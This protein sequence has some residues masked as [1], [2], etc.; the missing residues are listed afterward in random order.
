MQGSNELELGEN[1][2]LYNSHMYIIQH[3]MH[4]HIYHK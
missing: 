2:N 3:Y 1:C 4:I